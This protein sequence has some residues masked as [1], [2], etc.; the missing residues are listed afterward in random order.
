MIFLLIVSLIWAFSFGVIKG[1]LTDLDSNFVSFIRL[2]I[3]FLVFVPFM[4]LNHVQT[5]Q[6]FN[7]IFIGV[8]QYGLM[9][10]SY[11]YAYQFLQSYEVALFTI[12]TPLY[13]TL[14][15]DALSKK[16]NLYFFIAATLSVLGAGIV[17][18][19]NFSDI[20]L[21][22]GVFLV[23]ISN[24][25][26]AVGQ[27]L[28]KNV[29]QKIKVVKDHELFGLLFLGGAIVTLIFSLITTDFTSISFE[30]NQIF[31][32][33]YLG[34]IA[35]GLGFFL[36][37]FGARKTNVGALAV[38]NN[39]KIPLAI[40]VSLIVFNE[41]ANIT[42]LT[43]GGIIIIISLLFNQHFVSKMKIDVINKS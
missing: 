22:F 26:F 34:V 39:L 36:W 17:V 37:N 8:I 16:I 25:C 9:Y 18:Y 41:S 10:A 4:K 27:V 6:K 15:N 12:F 13:L 14:F 3:S 38:F 31:A 19:K 5:R 33:I 11:I 28:Y 23:Q 20:N 24:I 43:I 21:W 32:L 29:M 1:S 7:L 35:S 42:G 2:F 40:F 30:V